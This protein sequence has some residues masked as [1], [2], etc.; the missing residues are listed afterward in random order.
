MFLVQLILKELLYFF[1]IYFFSIID[2]I[3]VKNSIIFFGIINIRIIIIFFFF[4]Y[5]FSIINSINLKNIIIFGVIN[6]IIFIIINTKYIMIC[7]IN[8]I[9]F[10]KIYKSIFYCN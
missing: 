6:N 10:S 2:S 4:I 1:L 8:I 3:G 5:F 7:I 9:I